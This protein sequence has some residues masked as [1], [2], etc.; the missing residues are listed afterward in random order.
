MWKIN[1]IKRYRKNVKIERWIERER[2]RENEWFRNIGRN[3]VEKKNMEKYK[4]KS[5]VIKQKKIA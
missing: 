5:D 3:Y 2:D 1:I 4:Y